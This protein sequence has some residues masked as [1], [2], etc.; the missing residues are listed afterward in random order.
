MK[1][2]KFYIAGV[3]HRPGAAKAIKDLKPGDDLNLV[4]EP[5]NKYDPNA[6]KIETLEGEFLGYV[7]KK[8]SSTVSAALMVD[9]EGVACKVTNV[10]PDA[11][12]WE[13]CE[14]EV[15]PEDDFYLDEEE[16]EEE[17]SDFPY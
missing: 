13:M 6:V 17:E 3:Q 11:K 9:P 4:P 16:E 1:K 2:L 14:V 7:P 8:F 15:G 12:T 5:E 10:Q